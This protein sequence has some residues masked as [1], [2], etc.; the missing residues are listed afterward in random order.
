MYFV[1]YESKNV[2]GTLKKTIF[3]YTSDKTKAISELSRLCNIDPFQLKS[4][5]SLEMEQFKPTTGY[6]LK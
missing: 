5:Y 2:Y 3:G 6:E 1:L 4:R